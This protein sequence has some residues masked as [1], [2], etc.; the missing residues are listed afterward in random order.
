[1]IRWLASFGTT[2]LL[3]TC[4]ALLAALAGM[5]VRVHML[6]ADVSVAEAA[7]SS[8]AAWARELETQRDAWKGAA[9]GYERASG[10]WERAFSSVHELLRQAQAEAGRVAEANRAA[11]AAAAAREAEA[12]RALDAW[13]TRYAE[14]VRAS[15][16]AS[17][18]VAVQAACPALE[19]Y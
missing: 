2:P 5:G 17:A 16:C 19:G 9:Q 11:V 10:E 7:S 4:A 14:Q 12:N 3:W 6:K 1:M 13:M 8:A 18:L 15:D